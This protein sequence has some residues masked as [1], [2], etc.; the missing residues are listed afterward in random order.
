[1]IRAN[2]RINRTKKDK[3]VNRAL[4][5]LT[6]DAEESETVIT[7][8]IL[9]RANIEVVIAGI[10]NKEPVKCCLNLRIIPDCDLKS[11]ESEIFDCVIIPGGPGAEKLAEVNKIK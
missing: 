3:M 1:M 2:L 4:L 5:L 9:R 6:D 7:V 10:N 8:D 11:C